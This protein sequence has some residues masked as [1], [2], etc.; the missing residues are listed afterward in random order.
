[1]VKNNIL[2]RFLVA[3]LYGRPLLLA[4]SALVFYSGVVLGQ[5][6][7]G[8]ELSAPDKEAADRLGRIPREAF[9]RSS[10]FVVAHNGDSFFYNPGAGIIRAPF[11]PDVFKSFGSHPIRDTSYI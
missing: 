5:A 10:S 2:L 7:P 11:V 3:A 1:M 6:R 4:A 8:P 9:S